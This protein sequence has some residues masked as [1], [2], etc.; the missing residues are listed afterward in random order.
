LRRR[1]G[2]KNDCRGTIARRTRSLIFR[3]LLFENREGFFK[4]RNLCQV[5]RSARCAFAHDDAFQWQNLERNL[6]DLNALGST[7]FS[8]KRIQA[9]GMSDDIESICVRQPSDLRWP[10]PKCS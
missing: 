2:T 9:I 1:N 4:R 5:A 3:R 7:E 8:F 10:R 6:V